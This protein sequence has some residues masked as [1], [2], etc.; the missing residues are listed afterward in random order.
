MFNIEAI[1]KFFKN[2]KLLRC[3]EYSVDQI[4][5]LNLDKLKQQNIKALIVDFDGVLAAEGQ[6][7]PLP[8]AISWLEQA[9]QTFGVN[10][11][12]IFSN[13]P[14]IVRQQFFE[15]YFN[16]HIIFIIA[17]PK[18]DT[19]GL[20]YAFNY[21][22]KT[23]SASIEKSQILMLD[24]RLATGIL[25]AKIF[26]I[27]SCLIQQPYVNLKNNFAKELF[28][29]AVRGLERLTIWLL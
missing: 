28:Y 19:E 15:K 16:N 29:I 14:T 10:K 1:L 4:T 7:T 2:R 26:G 11:I 12:F 25:A 6:P 8:E 18:P 5:Y 13:N 24:D 27:A 23:S 21:L 20:S 3:L 9:I 22:Q 17:K